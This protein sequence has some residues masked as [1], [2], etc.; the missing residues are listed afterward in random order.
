MTWVGVETN[1]IHTPVPDELLQE[2]EAY[3]R[4]IADGEEEDIAMQE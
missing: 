2:A 1:G 3:A 4:R